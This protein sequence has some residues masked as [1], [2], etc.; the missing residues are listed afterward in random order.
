MQ[1]TVRAGG[2]EMKVGIVGLPQAGATTVFNALTG[3]HGEV[4]AFHPGEHVEIGTVRV[5]DERLDALTQMLGPKEVMPASIEFED[6]GGVF[7]HLAGGQLSGH[8]VAA[9]RDTD[10]ILM[11]LRSFESPF[12]LEVFGEVDPGHEYRVMNEEM[13]LRLALPEYILWLEDLAPIMHFESFAEISTN[14]RTL[15]IAE[16]MGS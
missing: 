6:V 13:L 14:E 4:G 16:V 7:A 8:A 10:A 1:S 3:A 15:R 12:V 2:A 9:L 11:V 5:P